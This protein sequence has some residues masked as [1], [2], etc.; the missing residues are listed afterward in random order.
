MVSKYIIINSTATSESTSS[1]STNFTFK[2][3]QQIEISKY[4]KLLYCAIPCSNYLISA[5]NNNLIITFADATVKNISIASQNYTTATLATAIQTAVNYASFAMVFDSNLSKYKLTASQNFSISG[6]M[7]K[8]LGIAQNQAFNSNPANTYAASSIN[9][10]S[11]Q[12]LYIKINEFSNE[13]IFT[14]QPKPV[15]FFVHNNVLKNSIIY[16]FAEMYDNIVSV[17]TNPVLLSHLHIQI[18]DEDFKI[19]D[20]LNIPI[21]LILP[22]V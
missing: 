14:A 17:S 6:S 18:L 15:S 19:Y 3:A 12:I 7:C 11:P 8:T 5:S 21:Q 22:F 13:N 20:N 2:L 1:T 10:N 4:L 16:Y 9:F